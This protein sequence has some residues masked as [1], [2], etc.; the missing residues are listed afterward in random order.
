VDKLF[1]FGY[2]FKFICAV[3][4]GLLLDLLLP[5]FTH[6]ISTTKWQ[7]NFVFLLFSELG[8]MDLLLQANVLV[9]SIL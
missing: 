5:N 7:Q 6:Q 2:L 4:T 1:Y 9:M 8:C 3:L